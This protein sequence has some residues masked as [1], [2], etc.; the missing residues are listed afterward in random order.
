MTL[1]GAFWQADD[2]VLL[3]PP[4]RRVPLMIGSNGPRVLGLTLPH[5]DAWNT[6]YTDYGNTAEGFAALDARISAAA[7]DAGRDPATLERSACVLVVLDRATA[8]RPLE[9]PPLEG[10]PDAIAAR[11]RELADAGADE[12]ILVLGPI[13]EASIRALGDVLAA[14]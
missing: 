6:W 4:A 1:D 2:A 12:A 3:P 9:V 13:T 10:T 8:E 11:L 7:R 5:A 14:L